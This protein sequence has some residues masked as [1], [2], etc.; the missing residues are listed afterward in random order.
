MGPAAYLLAPHA[1]LAWPA[2]PAAVA[3]RDRATDRLPA[4][5]WGR[6]VA[7]YRDYFP[8]P[9]RY[10]VHLRSLER[11]TEQFPDRA[12]ARILLAYQYG[13][14]GFS[15]R[16]IALLDEIK[17]DPLA[18]RLREH[19]VRQRSAPAPG[20]EIRGPLLVAPGPPAK[21]APPAGRSGPREF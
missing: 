4:D 6:Y 9:L 19:F 7:N 3:A 2:Y 21:Q 20:D 15:D 18:R 17:A 12:E 8:S 16:A 14:L 5:Q 13:S 1:L 11:F 10:V